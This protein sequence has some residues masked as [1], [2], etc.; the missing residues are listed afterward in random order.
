MIIPQTDLSVGV[1][2]DCLREWVCGSPGESQ[3]PALAKLCTGIANGEGHSRLAYTKQGV[4]LDLLKKTQ[5]FWHILP[6]R[7]PGAS[8]VPWVSP[9]CDLGAS[10]VPPGS[11]LGESTAM[12]H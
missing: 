11:L 4:A 10:W 1:L 6:P 9:G 2:A 3:V 5:W 7:P 12:I 8:W